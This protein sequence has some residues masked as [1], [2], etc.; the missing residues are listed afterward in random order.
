MDDYFFEKE[1]LSLT[2]KQRI[3]RLKTTFDGLRQ[4]GLLTLVDIVLNHT[5]HNSE[6]II[7]HPEATYNTDDCPHLWSAWELDKGLRDFSREYAKRKIPEC[8]SAPYISNE[9]DL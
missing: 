5:A 8:P 7:D 2:P 1:E 6:W 3:S 9:G 4:Q